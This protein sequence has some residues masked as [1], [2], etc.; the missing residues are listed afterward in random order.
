MTTAS[1]TYPAPG[2]AEEQIVH[3]TSL[4]VD[5]WHRLKKN[6]LALFGLGA[7]CLIAL[8]CLIGPLLTG[9]GY[10]QTELSLKASAPL[11]PIVLRTQELPGVDPRKNFIALTNVADDF[12]D[13]SDAERDQITERVARGETLKEGTFTY[14]LSNR[15][16]LLGTDALGRDLLTRL[17]VGGRISLAVG[18]AATL[19]A[20][21][22]GVL[23]GAIAGFA[24]GKIDDIMM[25]SADII[26]ALPFT[27]VVILLMVL[28][29]QN[30]ILLFVA[31][32]LVEWITMARIVRG[33]VNSLKHQ[34]FIEAAV[35]LGLGTWRIMSRHLI[36][37]VLGSIIIYST[38][39]VPQIMLLEAILSFLG[40]GVQ[41]PLSSWG[42]LIDDGAKTMETSPWLL[43]FPAAIFSLTLFSLNFLGDGLRD[44]LDPKSSKD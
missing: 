6:H 36:P 35:S 9:Y 25:R 14:Q 13:R 2:I 41:P 32:G 11:V 12:L 40:L 4:W 44:A 39:M 34:E 10:E 27:V 15:R 16:H 22:V 38:L 42:V 43:L 24:G 29:G 21:I 33:Q 26:Y 19:V 31:I 7:F 5:A 28:F 8:A 23:W 18:F 1:T 17:F 20:A 37:N 30:F 3:G